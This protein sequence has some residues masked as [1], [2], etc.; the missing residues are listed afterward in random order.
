MMVP[1]EPLSVGSN[2]YHREISLMDH[3]NLCCAHYIHIGFMMEGLQFLGVLQNRW[4]QKIFSICPLPV[5]MGKL[6]FIIFLV[7]R[8]NLKS[9]CKKRSLV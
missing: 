3:F 8:L 9:R 7:T 2:G 5:L 4:A 1:R 6:I